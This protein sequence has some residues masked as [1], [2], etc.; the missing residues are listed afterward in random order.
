MVEWRLADISNSVEALMQMI[1]DAYNDDQERHNWVHVFD[2][3][4]IL[5]PLP[6]ALLSYIACIA[7]DQEQNNAIVLDSV[8]SLS[9]LH[10]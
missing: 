2:K 1:V 3:C 5:R 8:T 6:S 9:T 7:W 10:T 4:L